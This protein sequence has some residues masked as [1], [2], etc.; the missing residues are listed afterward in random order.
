VSYALAGLQGGMLGVC[1]MLAWLGVSASWQRRSFW[2]TPN[3]MATAFY[4][5]RAIRSGFAARTLSGVALYLVLYSLLGV[6]FAFLVR[7]RLPRFRTVLAALV[8]SVAWYYIAFQIVWRSVL[9]LVYLLHAARPMLLGHLIYGTFVGRY[10]NYL[11]QPHA[12]EPPAPEAPAQEP[13]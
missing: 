10:P 9:P 6:L 13:A 7:D 11:P 8:F 12:A 5:E 3:L 4:G 1:W 2:T